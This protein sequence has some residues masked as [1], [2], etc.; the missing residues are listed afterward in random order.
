MN[1]TNESE[2]TWKKDTTTITITQK[3]VNEQ[4]NVHRGN[5]YIYKLSGTCHPDSS[6]SQSYA[7]GN[8]IAVEFS[9]EWR[10]ADRQ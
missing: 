3:A 7:L 10:N 5:K 8:M 6:F 9:I 1:A 2:D 4:K